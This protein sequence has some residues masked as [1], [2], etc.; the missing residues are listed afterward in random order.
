MCARGGNDNIFTG[1]HSLGLYC[2]GFEG[3]DL[4]SFLMIVVGVP[5][6]FHIIVSAMPARFENCG[7]SGYVETGLGAILLEC[8]S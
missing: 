6:G 4:S 2:L 8:Y 1:S 7:V 3:V 5:V